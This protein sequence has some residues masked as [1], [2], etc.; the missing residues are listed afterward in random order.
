MTEEPWKKFIDEIV[1][2]NEARA[3]YKKGETMERISI[4]TICLVIIAICQ[5]A[6]VFKAY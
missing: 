6:L 3:M 4:A 5:I 1:T 2:P